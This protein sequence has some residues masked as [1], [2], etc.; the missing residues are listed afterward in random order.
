MFPIEHTYVL[1][2]LGA[3][4]PGVYLVHTIA[5]AQGYARVHTH[6]TGA[7]RERPPSRSDRT[8]WVNARRYR[9][10]PST[11]AWSQLPEQGH[12]RRILYRRKKMSE[13][14]SSGMCPALWKFSALSTFHKISL[15][16]DREPRRHQSAGRQM[17]NV[18]ASDS[19][20]YILQYCCRR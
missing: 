16:V 14:G 15:A 9:P 10:L 2:P 5:R 20:I 1:R 18:N 17:S 6:K 4:K 3:T 19:D 7:R 12:A 8:R 13:N 11:A